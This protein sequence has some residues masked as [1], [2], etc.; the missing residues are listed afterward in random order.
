VKISEEIVY[1]FFLKYQNKIIFVPQ[2]EVIDNIAK[3]MQTTVEYIEEAKA[4]TKK[5]VVF[6]GKAR[7]V[8]MTFFFIF[9]F[10]FDSFFF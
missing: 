8:R 1:Y 5:A 10:N 2:G 9:G 4:E 3:N 6:Q 7:R